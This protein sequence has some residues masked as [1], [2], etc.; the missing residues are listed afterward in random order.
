MARTTIIGDADVAVGTAGTAIDTNG[1]GMITLVINAAA[2]GTLAFTECDTS[3]G[4]YTNVDASDMIL[5]TIASAGAFLGAYI[6]NKRYIKY[7][8]SGTGNTAVILK[9]EK[10]MAD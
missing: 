10:R 7:T 3:D 4:S 9:T 1:Y 5:P 8:L 2:A 6:G